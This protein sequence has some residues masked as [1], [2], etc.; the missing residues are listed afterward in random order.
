MQ[1]LKLRYTA[2]M[3]ISKCSVWSITDFYSQT[4]YVQQ[5]LLFLLFLP[6]SNSIYKSLCISKKHLV[7]NEKE[8][9]RKQHTLKLLQIQ[10]TV[11]KTLTMQNYLS[12]LVQSKIWNLKILSPSQHYVLFLLLLYFKNSWQF[13]ENY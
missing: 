10:K 4:E 5:K 7:G 13:L 2:A 6:S 9:I 1:K 8:L 3:N 12:S 11:L